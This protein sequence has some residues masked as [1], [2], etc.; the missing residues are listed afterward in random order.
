MSHQ[1]PAAA[2]DAA[3][4]PYDYTVYT[5]VC[6]AESLRYYWTTYGSHR[7]RYLD[8]GALL[9]RRSP[10]RFP[11]DQTPDFLPAIL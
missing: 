2:L 11:L 9:E 7:V 1:T 3:V 8:L 10:L 6:C 4:L 5:A